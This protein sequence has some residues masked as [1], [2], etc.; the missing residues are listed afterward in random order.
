MKAPIALARLII[1]A[2]I[3][4]NAFAQGAGSMMQGAGSAATGAAKRRRAE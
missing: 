2:F 3:P 4:Y 1:S